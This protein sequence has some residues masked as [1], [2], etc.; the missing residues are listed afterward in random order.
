MFT[1]SGKW[2]EM[3]GW[4]SL[5]PTVLEIITPFKFI[6]GLST[7]P[8]CQSTSSFCQFFFGYHNISVVDLACLKNPI[9][10]YGLTPSVP[11]SKLS[12]ICPWTSWRPTQISGDRIQY[13]WTCH[14]GKKT[15][16]SVFQDIL[17]H[18]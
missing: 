7:E 1:H 5:S 17:E 10:S 11:L 4:E 16:P 3:V 12:F 14:D 8:L 9:L 6:L 13:F 2:G 15:P 18:Q